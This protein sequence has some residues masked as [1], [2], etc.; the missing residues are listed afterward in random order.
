MVL[1]CLV[2]SRE[3]W[4]GVLV[5]YMAVRTL[6]TPTPFA[7]ETAQAVAF[8]SVG[9]VC[10]SWLPSGWGKTLGGLLAVSAAFQVLVAVLEEQGYYPLWIGWNRIPGVWTHGTL[11]NPNHLG[12]YLAMTIAFAPPWALPVWA[13]GLALSRS[14]LAALSAAVALLL[15]YRT[16]WRTVLIGGLILLAVVFWM[17]GVSMTSWHD[18]VSIAR[19]AVQ[20]WAFAPVFGHGPGSWASIG[21]RLQEAPQATSLFRGTAAWQEL[22]N[23]PLQLLFE[24]GAVGVGLLTVWAWTARRRLLAGTAGASVAALAVISLGSFP[25]QVPPL[26][27]TAMAIVGLACATGKE[28]S[29]QRNS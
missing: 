1:G 25:F 26:A 5:G 18:R 15:V 7:F 23:E 9:I 22:H 2:G 16:R 6:W 13:L 17:R 28:K 24:G 8:L 14:V 12:S 11:G 20:A 21:P 19:V 4:L 27:A 10:V 3:P 29:W